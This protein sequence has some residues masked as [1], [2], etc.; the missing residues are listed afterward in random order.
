V[1]TTT[2]TPMIAVFTSHC[3]Y[4]VSLNRNSKFLVVGEPLP[5]LNGLFS[6][7]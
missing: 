3:P 6:T 7:L 5:N 1:I 4:W 2:T